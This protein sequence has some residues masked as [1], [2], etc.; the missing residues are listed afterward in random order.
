MFWSSKLE[1]MAW[2]QDGVVCFILEMTKMKTMSRPQKYFKLFKYQTSNK[3]CP[4]QWWL[5]TKG[6]KL[7]EV[8]FVLRSCSPAQVVKT[9]SI[10]GWLR[11][12]MEIAG[13]GS[14]SQASCCFSTHEIVKS[15]D[16]GD[17]SSFYKSY[18]EEVQ[19]PS[20]ENFTRN[21]SLSLP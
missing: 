19:I 14:F 8:L 16:W 12:M 20:T 2:C 18:K 21:S 5:L 15:G 6:N 4:V 11:L 9:C 10:A 13:M 17:A 7:A 3:L 1:A